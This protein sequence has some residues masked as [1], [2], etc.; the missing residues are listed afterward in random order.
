MHG[1]RQSTPQGCGDEPADDLDVSSLSL[2]VSTDNVSSDEYSH[3]CCSSYIADL[4]NLQKAYI[5]MYPFT[6]ISVEIA[7]MHVLC[8]GAESSGEDTDIVCVAVLVMKRTP[9]SWG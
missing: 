8:T 4:C 2:A 6:T 7:S 9:G 5:I 1:V 3:Q